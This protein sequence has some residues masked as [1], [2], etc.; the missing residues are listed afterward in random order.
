MKVP[1]P[2]S[3][4]KRLKS[5]LER[6]EEKELKLAHLKVISIVVQRSPPPCARAHTFVGIAHIQYIYIHIYYHGF[7]C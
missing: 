3:K 7:T 2:G 4:V 1:G 6:A 5:L